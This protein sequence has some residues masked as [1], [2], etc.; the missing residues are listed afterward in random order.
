MPLASSIVLIKVATMGRR[1]Y[2]SERVRV[3]DLSS[4]QSIQRGR[5]SFELY[6]EVKHCWSVRTQFSRISEPPHKWT[7]L[8]TLRGVLSYKKTETQRFNKV[9]ALK[10]THSLWMLT[11]QLP[12]MP[13]TWC[14]PTI[15][16]LMCTKHDVLVSEHKDALSSKHLSIHFHYSRDGGKCL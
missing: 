1:R 16:V 13:R 9:G 5:R 4:L 6:Q 2:V 12:S 11:T 3:K 10:V 14:P 7:F 8:G 15:L